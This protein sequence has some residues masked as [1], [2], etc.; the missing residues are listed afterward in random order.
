MI[1]IEKGVQLL[2]SAAALTMNKKYKEYFTTYANKIKNWSETT[3]L[4]RLHRILFAFLATILALLFGLNVIYQMRAPVVQPELINHYK[5]LELTSKQFTLPT[6]DYHIFKADF[7]DSDHPILFVGGIYGGLVFAVQPPDGTI[8]PNDKEN[9]SKYN[10]KI[11]RNG[12]WTF[13]QKQ[14]VHYEHSV[15]DEQEESD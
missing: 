15:V 12:I 3:N 10:V 4:K 14:D 6:G 9:C 8:L 2:H 1:H 11:S 13:Y 7:S 5:D